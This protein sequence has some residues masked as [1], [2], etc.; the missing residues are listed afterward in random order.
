[1]EVQPVSDVRGHWLIV[2]NTW[3]FKSAMDAMEIP[4]QYQKDEAGKQQVVRV[5]S[6]V[7]F[8]KQEQCVTQLEE[9]LACLKEGPVVLRLQ[10]SEKNPDEFIEVL[11]AGKILP[12]VR[13]DE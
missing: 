11:A 4:W 1:M 2:G 9:V 12:R 8:S 6:K 13:L 5:L 10:V 7:D 3:P